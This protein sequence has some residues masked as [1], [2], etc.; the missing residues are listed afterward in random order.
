MLQEQREA[1]ADMDAEF[2]RE[3]REANNRRSPNAVPLLEVQGI[4]CAV[5][6]CNWC[7]FPFFFCFS[8]LFGAMFVCM[9]EWF[10]ISCSSTWWR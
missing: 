6:G 1:K 5:S 9:T 4:L 8:C 10:V 7:S 3:Q 2:E